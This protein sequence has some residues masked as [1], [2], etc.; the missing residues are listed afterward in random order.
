VEFSPKDVGVAESAAVF[1][2]LLAAGFEAFEVK[3]LY[4]PHWYLRWREPDPLVP[5]RE[6]PL[7]VSD[8]LF[9]RPPQR[10]GH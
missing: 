5:L 1:D 9:R 2:G 8:V 4:D 3:N 6:L 7:E 10:P